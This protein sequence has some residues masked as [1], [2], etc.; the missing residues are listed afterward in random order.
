[1]DTVGVIDEHALYPIHEEDSV[2]QDSAHDRQ[3]RYLTDVLET[4][5]SD[6]WVMHDVPLYWER[7]NMEKYRAPDVSVIA[8]PKP[9]PLP[10]LYLA[11]QDPPVLFVAE[12]ASEKTR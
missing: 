4:H 1:M 11:W 3:S 2:V 12:V 8:G 6:L 7:G 10:R 5:Q 9:S